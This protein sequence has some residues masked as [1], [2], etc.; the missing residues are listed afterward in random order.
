MCVTLSL[1]S[2]ISA[3]LAIAVRLQEVRDS[4]LDSKTGAD[5]VAAVRLQSVRGFPLDLKDRR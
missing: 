5:P 3:D 4:P 1:I 2:K